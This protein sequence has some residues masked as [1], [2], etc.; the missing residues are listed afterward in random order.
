MTTREANALHNPFLSAAGQF[1]I[2]LQI[3]CT[4]HK[5]DRAL[6]GGPFVAL[7]FPDQ[8]WIDLASEVH[9]ITALFVDRPRAKDLSRIANLPLQNFTASYPARATDWSFLERLSALTRLSVH[10]TA[11]F[12]GLAAVATLEQLEVFQLSGGYSSVL[13]LPSLAP[14]GACRRLVA[15]LLA[16][17]RCTDWGL[18]PIRRLPFLRRFDCPLWWPRAEIEALINHRDG[19]TSNVTEQA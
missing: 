8:S 1:R 6:F 14:L 13:R 7:A 2:E 10:N 19:V 16:A 4:A 11:S 3:D 9:T 5:P 17:V 18:E 15:I 12:D